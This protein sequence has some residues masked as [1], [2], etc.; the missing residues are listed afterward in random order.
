MAMKTT[1]KLLTGV[2]A[3]TGA[4]L[5]LRWQM[6]RWFTEQPRVVLLR[7]VAPHIELRRYEPMVVAGTVVS[8]NVAGSGERARLAARARLGAFLVGKNHRREDVRDEGRAHG[9]RG[10]VRARS[11]HV[12]QGRETFATTTPVL[13]LLSREHPDARRALCVVM[14]AGRDLASLPIPDDDRVLLEEMPARVVGVIR[15]RGA[16][17]DEIVREKAD[18]LLAFLQGAGYEVREGAIVAASY[19]PPTTLR[20]LRRNEVWLE[21]I[22]AE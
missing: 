1:T 21:V 15:W 7:R 14:P 3:L 11:A 13:E 22:V 4:A 12:K 18:E 17:D 10:L 2:A 5:T 19:D 9:A 8:A 16:S 20:S 6:R